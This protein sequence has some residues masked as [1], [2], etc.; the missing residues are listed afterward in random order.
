MNG[1]L[2][3]LII[4]AVIMLIIIGPVAA[5]WAVNTLFG[6]GI[7]INITTWFAAFLLMLFFSP[8]SA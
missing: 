5:I 6:L 3:A 4:F 8:K 1:I 7:D 2:L